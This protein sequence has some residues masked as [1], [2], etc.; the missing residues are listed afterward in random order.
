MTH[1][2]SFVATIHASGPMA[3]LRIQRTVSVDAGLVTFA[4]LG[5]TEGLA[6]LFKRG[7]TF[8]RCII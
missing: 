2:V 5:N 8:P 4:K 3:A 1:A 7:R 6:K